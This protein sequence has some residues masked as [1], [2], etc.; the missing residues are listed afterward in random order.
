LLYLI[1]AVDVGS[2]WGT[3]KIMYKFA[4]DHYWKLVKRC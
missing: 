3:E 4:E 2:N 1:V